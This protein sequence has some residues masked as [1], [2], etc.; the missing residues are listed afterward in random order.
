MDLEENTIAERFKDAGYKTA[1]FGKW[2]LGP[3]EEYWP[4]H[5]G[6]DLNHGGFS[7]GLPGGYFLP[8]KIPALKMDPMAS[9]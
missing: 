7:R 3:T 6:F 9:I 1:F 5:Q 4:K 8:I 2:H